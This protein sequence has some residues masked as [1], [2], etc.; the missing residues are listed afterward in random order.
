MQSS[1]HKN[2]LGFHDP[3]DFRRVRDV[4]AAANYSE[5]GITEFLGCQP[6]S[7]PIAVQLPPLILQRNQGTPLETL[8]RLF[9]VGVET[10]VEQTRRAV[11]PMS[12]QVWVEAGM[13]EVHSESVVPSIKIAPYQG[14]LLACDIPPKSQPED[15]ADFVMGI[16]GSTHSIANAAIRRPAQRTLDLGTGCGIQALL[17]AAHSEQVLAVDRNSRAVHFSRFNARLNGLTNID[18]FAGDLFQ[19]VEGHQFDLVVA[20]PPLVI[21][22]QFR[23]HYRD[24]GMTLDQFCEKIV[25]QVPQ[26]LR[27]GGYCQI[28]CN[29]AH[30]EGQKWQDRLAHWF[31]G[32]GCDAWV[33]RSATRSLSDYTLHWNEGR[34]HQPGFA[35]L[36]QEWMS[37]YRRQRIEAISTGLITMR[38]SPGRSNWFHA[39]DGPK[40]VSGP[41]GD[42]IVRGFQLFDFLQVNREDHTLLSTQ[43]RVAPDVRLEQQYEPAAQGGWQVT[44]GHLCRTRGLA[45]SGSIDPD[46]AILVASCNG[47]QRVGDLLSGLAARRNVSMESILPAY[48]TVVRRL[49]GRG[50]L[51]PAGCDEQSAGQLEN[52]KG[53]SLF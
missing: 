15:D 41:V 48:L 8:I 28:M 25:R 20:N 50:F 47:Q 34:E 27:E 10:D 12:L 32:T 19:P 21:S 14:L 18:F 7:T 6:P 46:A 44:K 17:A 53:V 38:R 37:Y 23:A 22:P 35:Q 39:E 24:S 11:Q 49:I 40:M 3:D 29:W 42:D 33:M 4:L 26:F 2:R 13:V 45:F 5:A 30:V 52:P 36:Y 16:C 1:R 51:V 31:Q 9:L 43:L